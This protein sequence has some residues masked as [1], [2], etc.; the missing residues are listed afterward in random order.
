M[1]FDSNSAW[2]DAMAAVKANRQVLL[3]VAGVF[4]LLPTLLSTVFLTDVQTQMLE[5]VGNPEAVERIFT[6]NMGLFLGFGIGGTLVQGVGYL[7]VMALLSDRGRPTVGEAILVALRAL[8]TLIGAGLLTILGLFMAS[9]V[10]GLVAG[11]LIGLVAGTGVA[12]LI[13]AL[14]VMAFATYLSVK[15]S[16]VVPV[17][18]NEALVSPVAAL[19]RSWRLTRNNSLRLFGFFVLLMIGYLAVAFMATIALVGPMAL[20]FGEGDA[21]TFFT[22]VVSGVIGAVASV[23]LTAVLA[24][25]HRQLAGPAPE[26]ISQTFE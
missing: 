1:K 20:I 16:L 22:G 2:L 24:Y 21:L 25:T 13:I 12:S 11:G 26:T 9:S 3:P 23:I 19:M 10:L 5:A 4:F 7:T 6:E 15:L 8:P 14:A 17:V 18:I